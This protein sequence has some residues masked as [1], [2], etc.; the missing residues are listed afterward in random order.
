MIN[1]LKHINKEGEKILKAAR[2][3][4]DFTQEQ[5]T[6]NHS[7]LLTGNNT[8][9]KWSKVFK[10]LKESL[11]L[12]KISFKHHSEKK[13]KSHFLAYKSSYGKQYGS[14]SKN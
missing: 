3:N 7:R 1:F 2:E 6:K 14:S 5:K 10:S 8:R 12:V 13:K 4:Q 9:D 11:D